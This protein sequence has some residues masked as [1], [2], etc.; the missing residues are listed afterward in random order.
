MK[1]NQLHI[2][3]YLIAALCISSVSFSQNERKVDVQPIT[4]FFAKSHFRVPFATSNSFFNETSRG[5]VDMAGSLNYSFIKNL[6]VGAGYKYTYY[7]LSEIKLNASPNEQYGAKIQLH[8]FY[9]EVSYFKELY[10]NFLLEGNIQVGQESILSTSSTC[11]NAGISHIKKGLFVAPNLNFYLLTEEVF[12]FYFS[13][14]YT[15]SSHGF[16]P[17]EV[18][19]TSFSGFKS[20]AYLGNY[21]SINVGLGIGFSFVKPR[22]L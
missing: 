1:I 20:D 8:G 21:G 19:E 14:G 3:I 12:S 10:E 18:C 17:E 11:E 15:F 13:L 6:Y 4:K 5:V 22:N 9:G 2:V 16:T 7:K